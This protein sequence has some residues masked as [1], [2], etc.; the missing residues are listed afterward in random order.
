[1]QS[2]IKQQIITALLSGQR[3][4]TINNI[5]IFLKSLKSDTRY[6]KEQAAEQQAIKILKAL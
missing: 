3:T 2:D 5:E 1:M 6:R 4:V